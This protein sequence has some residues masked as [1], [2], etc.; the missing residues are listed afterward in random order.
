MVTTEQF[1]KLKK[2]HHGQ[3]FVRRR[4][5]NRGEIRHDQTGERQ[6]TR[7]EEERANASSVRTSFKLTVPP[8]HS[9]ESRCKN[10]SCRFK[11]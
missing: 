4:R 3:R 1:L 6:K 9:P 7:E 10:F 8:D 11:V 5:T 2:Y